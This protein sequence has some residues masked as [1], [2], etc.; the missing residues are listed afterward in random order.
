MRKIILELA[1]TLD[2]FIEGLDGEIDWLVSDEE[3]DFGDILN[4][5]LVDIDAIFYGR[6]SYELWGSYLPPENASLKLKN[7]YNLLH[8]K[9][10]YV[11]ST[12]VKNDDG[13]A[14][15]INSDIEKNVIEIL[16][17]PGKNI[18]LYGGGK[19]ITMF[20][21]LGLVDI[22]RLAVHPVIL[23]NGK[24]LFKDIK[25][26]VKLK[27]SN[28]TVSKSGMILLTYEAERK[29]TNR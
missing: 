19:L 24:P 21:N 6:V 26:R 25:E 11:F 17:Q 12:N 1:V 18:W 29:T 2:G 8:S 15:F 20:I 9:S 3:A 14:I 4:E 13:N 16:Q 10:K 27:S 23:G 5:I 7:A 28:A 22:Y